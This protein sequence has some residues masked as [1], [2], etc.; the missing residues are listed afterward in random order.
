[1]VLA[2]GAI[3]GDRF[4]VIGPLGKGGMGQVVSVVDREL[5]STRLALKVLYQHLVNDEQVLSRFRNEV[6]NARCLNHRQI[7][8]TYELGRTANNRYYISMELIDGSD[9]RD[10]LNR[11]N[12]QGLEPEKAINIIHQVASG[13]AHAH[14][15]GV[16][17]RD[18]KPRNILVRSNGDIK[19]SDFGLSRQLDASQA[20]TRTGETV[21]TP[22]YMSP[23]QFR[24]EEPDIRS[25]IYS[26][27]IV[28]YELVTGKVP[29]HD[30]TYYHLAV[31]H[32][33]Q[34]LPDFE[35]LD[36]LKLPTWYR[37]MVRTCTEKNKENRFNSADELLETIER[38]AR[39]KGRRHTVDITSEETKT[40][41]HDPYVRKIEE[42]VAQAYKQKRRRYLIGTCLVFLLSIY[43]SPSL[44]DLFAIGSLMLHRGVNTLGTPALT[45][46]AHT[47]IRL[48]W[49]IERDAIDPENLLEVLEDTTE[50]SLSLQHEAKLLIR[51]GI[52]LTATDY[53]RNTVLHLAAKRG[54]SD[55]IPEILER[56]RLA[57]KANYKGETALHHSVREHDIVSTRA[58]AESSRSINQAD[59]DGNTPAHLAVHLRNVAIVR[60]LSR[61]KAD[62][63]KRN[64][65][66][67]T[68]LHIAMNDTNPNQLALVN[69][70]ISGGADVDLPDFKGR[71]SSDIAFSS[72]NLELLRLALR[73]ARTKQ[74]NTGH[75][76][77]ERSGEADKTSPSP[78]Q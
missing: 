33:S 9:V 30:D 74:G 23:E 58:I 18:I 34:P 28:A 50:D 70:L 6:I 12:G 10:I 61:H 62:L 4:E 66:G 49:G 21:G 64:R 68:P 32:L 42:S 57:D 27:G 72:K 7:V 20:I 46:S 73:H 29:F 77:K 26:I 47:P 40:D 75:P 38:G 14:R 16:I 65:E 55:I 45:R 35:G 19:I 11:R 24:G 36:S 76:E 48:L 54:W 44:R 31:K 15:N 59:H 69:E 13:I 2:K 17:H 8:R 37:H 67:K 71:K 43:S 1:M 25:D 5:G 63:N 3:I 51:A 60:E 53:K 52:P 41:G 22:L 39:L 78:T 56:A